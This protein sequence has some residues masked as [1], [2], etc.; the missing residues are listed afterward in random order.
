MTVSDV[1]GVFVVLGMFVFIAM[2]SWCIRRSPLAKRIKARRRR[3]RGGGAEEN[4]MES[5]AKMSRRQQK[6][7]ALEATVKLLQESRVRVSALD[8]CV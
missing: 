6:T 4:V 8:E 1:S 5:F 3:G 7:F 2:C